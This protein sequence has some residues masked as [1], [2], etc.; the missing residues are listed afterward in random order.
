M[1]DGEEHQQTWE[2]NHMRA[3]LR[4]S[5]WTRAWGLTL[6]SLGISY[7]FSAQAQQNPIVD[8][9]DQGDAT[10]D[11]HHKHHHYKFI[12]LGTF[13]ISNDPSGGGTASGILSARGIVVGQVDTSIPDPNYPNHC[14]ICGP[15]PLISHAFKWQDGSLTDLGALPGI[16]SSVANWISPKGLVAGFSENGALDPL[17][18]GVV[19]EINAVLWK[20]GEIVNL[21]TIEGGY[22]SDAQVVNDSG[23]VAGN[24]LNTIPDPFS[25]FGFQV[26]AFR[27]QNGVMEDLGT[28]GGP[29]AWAFF[30]NEGGQ[31]AGY[32]FINSIPNPVTGIPTQDPFVWTDGKMIDLGTLGGTFGLPNAMNNRGQVVG[33]SNLAGDLTFHPFLWDG[34]KMIDLGTFGGAYGEAHWINEAGDIVGSAFTKNPHVSLAFLWKDGVLTNLGAVRGDSCSNALGI[35]S[36]RQVVGASAET[37]AFVTNQRHAFL[38]ENDQMIDLNIFLP[39]SSEL[40]RL[41]DAY[42]INDRGEIVGIGVPPGCGDEFSSCGHTF[43]LIPCDE[44]HPGVEGCDYDTVDAETAAQARPAQITESSAPA[45][46]AKFAPTELMTRYRSALTRRNQR[47]GTLQK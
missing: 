8:V 38:W 30:M 27:W 4:V 16:N 25:P 26:R 14:L 19:P 36:K 2:G 23:Q 18:P 29:E 13:G 10:Q 7:N 6:L 34:K 1:K 5:S 41:T 47:F 12:D 32:S 21:G 20:D 40:Q 9:A 31:V 28:L 11:P 33:Q 39:P 3:V 35:N 44:N 45:R 17:Y 43:V 24:F 37:C 42:N 15:N 46:G 22:E